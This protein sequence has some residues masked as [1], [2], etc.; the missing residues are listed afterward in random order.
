MAWEVVSGRG[1]WKEAR[2]EEGLRIKGL[3][4]EGRFGGMVKEEEWAGERK[5]ERKGEER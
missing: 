3:I 1:W 4:W 2:A 5:R